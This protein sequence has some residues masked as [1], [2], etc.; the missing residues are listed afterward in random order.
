MEPDMSATTMKPTVQIAPDAER[1]PALD[2][3]QLGSIRHIGNLARQL[4]NDW[5]HMMGPTDMK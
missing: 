4:K 2:R 3:K 5:S 1:F